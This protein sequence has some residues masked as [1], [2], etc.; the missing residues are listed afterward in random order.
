M[1]ILSSLK[2]CFS[3]LSCFNSIRTS[4]YHLYMQSD[5]QCAITN[6]TDDNCLSYLHHKWDCFLVKHQTKTLYHYIESKIFINKLIL[7]QGRREEVKAG[8][9]YFWKWEKGS[10]KRFE[11]Y[12]LW[13]SEKLLGWF[14]PKIR[15][16]WVRFSPKIEENLRKFSPKIGETLKEIFSQNRSQFQDFFSQNRS[17]FQDIFSQN[18]SQFKDIF[19]QN[20]SQFKDIFSQTWSKFER[21]FLPKSE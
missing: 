9:G 17:Q 19:S 12:F 4:H 20:R 18:R 5:I 15:K 14:S 21:Y 11:V 6:I 16:I 8:G 2:T 7:V 13:K 10:K 1:K 3:S